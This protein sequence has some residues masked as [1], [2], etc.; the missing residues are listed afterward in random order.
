[1]RRGRAP[2]PRAGPRRT[3]IFAKGKNANESPAGGH[4]PRHLRARCGTNRYFPVL[5]RCP[6]SA[7]GGEAPWHLSTAA[8]RSGRFICHWQRSH[9]SPVAFIIYLSPF[10]VGTPL[11]RCPRTPEDGCPYNYFTN[12]DAIICKRGRF[13]LCYLLLG[14]FMI[15]SKKCDLSG[16]E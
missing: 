2:P 12:Y 1:M 16:A 3:F 7:F 10:P 6:T 5:L 14:A 4:G 11:L 8:T 9:R 13:I 15:Y